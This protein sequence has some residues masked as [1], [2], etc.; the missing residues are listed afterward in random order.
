MR[1]Y[2]TGGVA[3]LFLATSSGCSVG[4]ALLGIRTAQPVEG[5]GITNP[6]H[7]ANVGK[8]VF[9]TQKIDRTNPDPSLFANSFAD[10]DHIY[11]RV[12]VPSAFA[13]HF[14]VW[15]DGD[16][17]TYLAKGF[18]IHATVD[19]KPSRDWSDGRD[20]SIERAADS[21]RAVNLN[22][23][24]DP[25]PEQRKDSLEVATRWT[26]FLKTL[27]AGNHVIRLEMFTYSGAFRSETP[28][29]VGE[30]TLVRNNSPLKSG[31]TFAKVQEG[32][33][34]DALAAEALIAIQQHAADNAWKEKFERA[35]IV[36]R[37]WTID[38]HRVSGVIL[39]RSLEVAAFARWPDGHCTYQN[40]GVRQEYDGSHYAPNFEFDGVGDQQD[41]D[42][43]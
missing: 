11:G 33:K 30:F 17:S 25:D 3:A 29:A 16:G 14:A 36:S 31:F 37:G 42:C 2:I 10:T 6:V 12:Y 32:M 13:N 5:E 15:S 43:D 18:E 28:A 9:S 27:P 20:L 41:V 22:P 4:K 19:G 24:E 34:N 1:T 38:R 21:T 7:A 23:A 35:K 8:I 40:F 26:K 39:G